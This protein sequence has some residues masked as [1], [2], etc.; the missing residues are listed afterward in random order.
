MR[1]IFEIF[2]KSEGIKLKHAFEQYLTIRLS[3]CFTCSARLNVACYVLGV[4]FLLIYT[5]FLIADRKLIPEVYDLIGK[6]SEK[7]WRMN[8][9]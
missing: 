6:L 3:S 2:I 5:H 9:E 1:C 7:K 4:C 8:H